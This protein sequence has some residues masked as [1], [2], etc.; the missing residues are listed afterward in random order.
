[1]LAA[2]DQTHPPKKTTNFFMARFV[3]QLVL[4]QLKSSA[5]I[6]ENPNII[7]KPRRLIPTKLAEFERSNFKSK[8]R[9]KRVCVF[10][11]TSIYS[12][13]SNPSQSIDKLEIFKSVHSMIT[14]WDNI[15]ELRP[16]GS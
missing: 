3:Y 7:S 2:Q 8:H 4:T 9:A 1:M 15:L 11:Q 5:W 12:R 14:F 10:E 13:V 16:K 6:M